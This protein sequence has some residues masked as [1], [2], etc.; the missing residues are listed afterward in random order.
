MED[1]LVILLIFFMTC[2]M[3]ALSMIFNRIFGLSG[4]KA[5]EF[6]ERSKE[7]QENMRI[8]QATQDRELLLQAQQQSLA[9]TKEMMKKQLLPLGL[10]CII[11]FGIMA[12]VGVIFAPYG[13]GLLPFWIPILGDG[14]FAIYFIFSISISIALWL[15]KFLYRR[16]T[17]K[18]KQQKGVLSMFSSANQMGSQSILNLPRPTTPQNTTTTPPEEPDEEEPKPSTPHRADSWK[19]KIQN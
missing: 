17:G 9:L 8:A 4:E 7:V 18:V 15:V 10:R 1:G 16:M 5:R 2:G 3:V 13:T 6:Q 12:L 11:F 19:E 14:W